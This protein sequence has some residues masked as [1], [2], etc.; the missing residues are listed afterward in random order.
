MYVNIDSTETILS[1]KDASNIPLLCVTMY[2]IIEID[3]IVRIDS[4]KFYRSKQC[5]DGIY[6][7]D[8]TGQEVLMD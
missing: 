7:F 4:G 5:D 6:Y 2:T 3:R 8:T 1:L